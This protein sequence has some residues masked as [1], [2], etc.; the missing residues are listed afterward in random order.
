MAQPAQDVADEQVMGRIRWWLESVVAL[1]APPECAACGIDLMGDERGFCGGCEV[2]LERAERG[3]G[4]YVYGGPLADAIRRVKYGGRVEHLPALAHLLVEPAREHA[5]RVDAV[6][7]VPLHG[8]RLRERGFDHVAILGR[9]LARI[10][11]VPLRPERLRRLRATPSQAGLDAAG[12]MDNVRGA[13]AARPDS[14]RPRVL[15]FDDVRTT[16][17]TLEAAASALH[18]SGAHTVR[19]MTLAGADRDA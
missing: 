17:A 6:V 2:L 16:G 15:L 8:T 1:V 4:A 9:A 12:R 5:G 19:V 10:L 13:F 14:G 11:G 7:P 18:A 3:V